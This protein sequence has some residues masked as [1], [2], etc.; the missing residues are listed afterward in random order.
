MNFCQICG[1]PLKEAKTKPCIYCSDN[2]SNYSKFKTQHE[3][4]IVNMKATPSS[5]SLIRGDMFRLA[6]LISNSTKSIKGEI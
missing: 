2:C 3:C 5:V 6:N 4:S 1:N